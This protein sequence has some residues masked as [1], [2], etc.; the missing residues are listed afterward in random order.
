LDDKEY[1]GIIVFKIKDKVATILD[2]AVKPEYQGKGIGSK[3]ID[4]I[5]NQFSANKII[6]ETDDDAVE[7]YKKY[8]FVVT[9]TKLEFGTKRYIVIKEQI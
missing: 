5:F 9:N 7:F 8:G 1:K 4:Y 6:A 2:I 3:L